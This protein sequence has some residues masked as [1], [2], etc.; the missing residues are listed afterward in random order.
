VGLLPTV[1]E[2]GRN[3]ADDEGDEKRRPKATF[4]API[5]QLFEGVEPLVRAGF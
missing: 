1:P 4:H 3:H 2:I 5:L